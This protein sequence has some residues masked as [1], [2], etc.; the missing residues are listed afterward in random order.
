MNNNLSNRAVTIMKII[1]ILIILGF[2]IFSCSAPKKLDKI[3]VD[4]KEIYSPK[5]F[6]AI[7]PNVN[8][9]QNS[10]SSTKIV[11]NLVDGDSVLVTVNKNGWYKIRTDDNVQGW[12]RTDLLGPKNLSVFLK[13]VVFI[14]KI[15]KVNDTELFFDKK[16]QHKRIYFSYSQSF[17]TNKTVVEQKTR[18]LVR[19][20]QNKV[21]RGNV[22]ARVLQPDSDK[23]YLTINVNGSPN[24]EIDLPI[25]PFGRVE[26][27][28]SENPKELSLTISIPKNINNNRLITTARNISSIYPISFENVEIQFIDYDQNE[29]ECRLWFQE[30]AQGE[31]YKFNHCK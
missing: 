6:W 7:K 14:E 28:T 23:E 30:G 17:Y 21:Y 16:L 18:K 10:H 2:L 19:E 31:Q 15:A 8:I 25:L 29:R 24:P 20:Y 3:H 1:Y 4:V 11:G 13:A 12:I 22:T 5:Y 27:V 26:K 9:R